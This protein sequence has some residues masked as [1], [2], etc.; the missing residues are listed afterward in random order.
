MNVDPWAGRDVFEDETFTG[1][2]LTQATLA[3]HEFVRCRFEKLVL[4]ES[5]WQGVRLDDCEFDGCDLT[6]M[7]PKKMAARGVAFTRCR[8][9]GVDWSGLAPNPSF[10]FEEC[11]LQY[12]SFVE[13][14]LTS[15]PFRRCRMVETNFFDARL[16]EA[17]FQEC[18]MAGARFEQ[19]DLRGA[20]LAD[21]RGLILDPSK[22]T[23]TGCRVSVE[24]AVVVA[25]ALGFRV[26][27]TAS[28]VDDKPRAKKRR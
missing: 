28:D 27:G 10:V 3:G 23:V 16:V 19:C 24:T 14:N 5:N 26:A 18:E 8:L 2:E 13:V 15:T 12:A 1:I 22:N 25:A 20:D 7:Q 9:M 4:Q 17:V 6:R 21:S 11:N